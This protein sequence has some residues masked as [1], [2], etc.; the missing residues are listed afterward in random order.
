M[1]NSAKL[2][3]IMDIRMDPEYREKKQQGIITGMGCAHPGYVK[4]ESFA[5]KKHKKQPKK[6]S[7]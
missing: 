6:Q 4:F 2:Q 1:K 7:A 3:A 5:P